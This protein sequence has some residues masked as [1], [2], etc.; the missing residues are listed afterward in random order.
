MLVPPLLAVLVVAGTA[1]AAGRPDPKRMTLR[2]SDLPHGLAIVRADT[3][4]YDVARAAKTDGASVL[5]FRAHGYVD[6]YARD[7]RRKVRV[8]RD[9]LAGTF[10]AIAATSL[11][12][13]DA[14]A[15]WS[16]ARTV[17]SS[18]QH[19]FKAL[20]AGRRIGAESHLYTYA[21]NVDGYALR[22]YAVGWRDGRVRASVLVVGAKGHVSARQALRLAR[23][24]ESRI[25]SLTH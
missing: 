15:R 14:G 25:A 1:F 6:G 7:A 5:D 24:Q 18:G 19:H 21:A 3:G 12:Q 23:K 8:V 11:W 4:R 16:L 17:A 10:Q 13:A 2:L 9:I 20:P 22:V